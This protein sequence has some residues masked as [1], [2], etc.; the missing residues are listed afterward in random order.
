MTEIEKHL[1]T[2]LEDSEKEREKQLEEFRNMF[3]I[4][5]EEYKKVQEENQEIRRENNILNGK[6]DRL[7]ELLESKKRR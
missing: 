1:L 5:E 4:L 3:Q 7:I 6:L 2:A